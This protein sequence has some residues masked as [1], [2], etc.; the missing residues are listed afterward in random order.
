[1]VKA[2]C[3][4]SW[5][6]LLLLACLKHGPAPFLNHIFIAFCWRSLITRQDLSRIPPSDRYFM[7]STRDRSCWSL[8]QCANH[9]NF[10]TPRNYNQYGNLMTFKVVYCEADLPAWLWRRRDGQ[11]Q[12]CY[13]LFNRFVVN[14]SQNCQSQTWGENHICVFWFIPKYTSAP[15][16]LHMYDAGDALYMHRMCAASFAFETILPK[17]QMELIQHCSPRASIQLS[18]WCERQSQIEMLHHDLGPG[19]KYSTAEERERRANRDKERLF[20]RAWQTMH[21]LKVFTGSRVFLEVWTS[22]MSPI[23]S[24]CRMY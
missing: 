4:F 13:L 3:Q 15:K 12:Q 17:F 9:N 19:N 5:Q 24:R 16:I 18:L 14:V 20:G 7:K 1:M 10:K 22:A 8:M 2:R 11:N 23:N 6:Q 21:I